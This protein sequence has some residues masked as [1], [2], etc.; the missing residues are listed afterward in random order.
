M[1]LKLI[2]ISLLVA[3]AGCLVPVKTVAAKPIFNEDPQFINY[4]KFHKP[5]IQ[6]DTRQNKSVGISTIP[7]SISYSGRHYSKEEVQD[8]INYYSNAYG[9]D[10]S[11]PM[12]IAYC[13]S[14]Y[15]QFSKNKY[16]TASGVM[17]YLASTWANTPA[18]KL[19]ISVFDA[20]AN[21]KMAVS[22]IAL[23]GTA[24]W[25]ASKSCWNK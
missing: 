9:I 19:G 12:R 6:P 10:A 16:S 24:P 3:I 18:G 14:G 2:A 4:E 13:E 8:L 23:H 15:N 21:V 25:N 1:K 7:I 5:P 11:L 17:Q 20:D 22:S